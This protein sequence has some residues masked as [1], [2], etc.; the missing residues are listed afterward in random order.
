ME[1]HRVMTV[2]ATEEKDM[3][4][5]VR[6]KGCSRMLTSCEGAHVFVAVT[7]APLIKAVVS[8]KEHEYGYAGKD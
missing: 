4:C 8:E 5:L 2:T 1:C 7:E 3:Y 6:S